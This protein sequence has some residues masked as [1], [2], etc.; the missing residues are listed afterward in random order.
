MQ[1]AVV[2]V[3]WNASKLLDKVLESLNRQTLKPSKVLV[4]DNGSLDADVLLEMN[5]SDI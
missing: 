2:I 3:T 5:C 1:I 4:I